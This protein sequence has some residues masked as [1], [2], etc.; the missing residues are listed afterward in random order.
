MYKT[1]ALK[2][3]REHVNQYFMCMNSDTGKE[4][5]LTTYWDTEDV[6]GNDYAA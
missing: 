6:S 2:E 3:Q 4:V 5:W 1:K